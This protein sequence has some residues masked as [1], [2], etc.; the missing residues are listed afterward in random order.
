MHGSGHRDPTAPILSAVGRGISS[1]PPPK[2]TR[3]THR[4]A[5][6]GRPHSLISSNAVAVDHHHT[7]GA[8]LDA[9]RKYS[10]PCASVA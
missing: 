1:P 5:G 3:K 4:G 8:E 7:V 6:I 2:A 10:R 9:D